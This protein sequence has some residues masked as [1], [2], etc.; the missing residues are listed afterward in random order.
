MG[1][2]SVRKQ[3]KLE[4]KK[5]LKMAARTHRQVHDSLG[6]FI[7]LDFYIQDLAREFTKMWSVFYKFMNKLDDTPCTFDA[8][9]CAW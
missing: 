5:C 3:K 6:G 1:V 2:D 9:Q 7:D 8:H 4:A